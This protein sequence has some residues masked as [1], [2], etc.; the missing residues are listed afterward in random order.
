LE[1][2]TIK[3]L[4]ENVDRRRFWMLNITIFF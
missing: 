3:V 1:D 2:S 4:G